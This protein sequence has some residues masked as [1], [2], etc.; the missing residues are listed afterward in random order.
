MFNSEDQQS[1]LAGCVGNAHMTSE[2]HEVA[3]ITDGD[4]TMQKCCDMDR[5]NNGN[6]LNT[7]K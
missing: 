6:H 2:C 3:M 1:I 7:F 4:E 5:C